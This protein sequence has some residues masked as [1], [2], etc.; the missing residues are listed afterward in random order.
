MCYNHRKKALENKLKRL[1]EIDGF[2]GGADGLEIYKIKIEA[3]QKEIDRED[4]KFPTYMTW[5]FAVANL[6]IFATQAFY[7]EN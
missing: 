7:F 4:A 2:G 1:L 5:F 3:L 6:I